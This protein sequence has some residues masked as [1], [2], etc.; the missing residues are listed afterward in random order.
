MLANADAILPGK[1][2]GFHPA[3]ALLGTP[4]SDSMSALRRVPYARCA[5]TIV[6]RAHFPYTFR[7]PH[8]A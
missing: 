4:T 2:S 8:S 6:G 5:S 1:T 3:A 7:R